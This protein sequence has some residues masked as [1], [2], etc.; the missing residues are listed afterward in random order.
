MELPRDFD[1][2]RAH[3]FLQVEV[4]MGVDVGGMA[5]QKPAERRE[6]RSVDAG[7][8]PER[9][10]REAELAAREARV[11]RFTAQQKLLNL[12][13]PVDLDDVLVV[14]PRGDLE[15]LCRGRWIDNDLDQAGPIAQ[16]DED[17]PAVI[18]HSVNPALQDNRPADI[19][20]ADFRANASLPARV[21]AFRRSWSVVFRA[22]ASLPACS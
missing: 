18:A 16:I 13:L 14:Q 20:G 12:G 9:S 8:I 4:L 22:N 5:A 7:V 10:L 15:R 2:S 11:R 6:L 19:L 3:G 17:Q 1:Q 21:S